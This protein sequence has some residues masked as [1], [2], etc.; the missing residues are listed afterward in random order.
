MINRRI[1]RET[2]CLVKI[3]EPFKSVGVNKASF[4]VIMIILFMH[5][6]IFIR[7]FMLEVKTYQMLSSFHIIKNWNSQWKP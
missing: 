5:L 7:M 4:I 6:E 1:S 2:P 3:W